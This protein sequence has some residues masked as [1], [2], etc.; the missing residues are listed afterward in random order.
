[1]VLIETQQDRTARLHKAWIA[2]NRDK[3]RF[4]NKTYRIRHAAQ[5]A[6]T[7]KAWRE[8]N[9]E[10]VLSYIRAWT[11]RNPERVLQS[12]RATL[13]VQYALRTGKLRR[14]DVCSE[15]SKGC[16]PDAAHRDYS[17]PLEVRWLCRS[18]HRKWDQS[19]P[20]TLRRAS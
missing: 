16:K 11:S 2:A 6:L 7:D 20:K 9:H 4:H 10:R 1:M 8:A 15:C 12:K 5:K 13:A 19:E 18:C 17:K 14:P 3:V